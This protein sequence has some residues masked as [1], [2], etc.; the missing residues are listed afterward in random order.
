MKYL[1]LGVHNELGLSNSIEVNKIDN[2]QYVA[3]LIFS[4]MGTTPDDIF[5]IK[6]DNT[7][8]SIVHHWICMKH[9]TIC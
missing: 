3:N 8:P 5:I 2:P 1:A 9:Y 4:L 7:S 6:N